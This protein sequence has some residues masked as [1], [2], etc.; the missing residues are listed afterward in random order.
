MFRYSPAVLAL[1]VATPALSQSIPVPKNLYGN[2]AP[3]GDCARQPR[4]V[5]NTAG[6]FLETASGKAGPLPV[7][8][9]YSCAGGARY[10][11]IQVW[12]MVKYG[13]DKW[14]GDTFP[15]T[16]MF[17]DG[18]RRGALLLEHDDTM[19]IPIGIPM[20][21]VVQARTFRLCK[22]GRAGA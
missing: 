20:T 21:Q 2:Y 11:G 8:V 19:R 16:M 4:V 6:V 1:L 10:E 14:G 17:N 12:V 18:E 13:K 9:C 7:D 5:V 3:G 15:V 22:G